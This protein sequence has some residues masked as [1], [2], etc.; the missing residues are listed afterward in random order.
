MLINLKHYK[1]ELT[2]RH[3]PRNMPLKDR[4]GDRSAYRL[5]LGFPG[6]EKSKVTLLEH[7]HFLRN[8]FAAIIA[9]NAFQ[10]TVF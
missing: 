1:I 3:L 6:L 9:L 8:E 4:S 5:S 10:K 2:D 7:A